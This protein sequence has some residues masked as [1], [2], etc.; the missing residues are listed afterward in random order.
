MRLFSAGAVASVHGVS[1]RLGALACIGLASWTTAGCG[2]GG[3]EQLVGADALRDCLAKHGASFGSQR[4]GATGYATLF[5]L[6]ADLQ[7]RIAGSSISVF[8][9][10]SARAARRDA[11]D[12]KSALSA[13]GVNDPAGSVLLNRN[14][15]VAFEPPPSE[16]ARDAV[17]ACLAG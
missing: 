5:H 3:G 11:A 1:R 6:A 2:G 13:V 8:I 14:A 16:R 15:V 9:E 12:A 10:K 7:G 4:P 17:R